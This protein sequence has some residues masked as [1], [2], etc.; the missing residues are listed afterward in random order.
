MIRNL[1]TDNFENN[2]SYFQYSKVTQWTKKKELKIFLA[3]KIAWLRNIGLEFKEIVLKPID[4]HSD[5]QKTEA[6]NVKVE[7]TQKT[8]IRTSPRKVLLAKDKILMS[9]KSYH[10]FKKDLNLNLPS[11][12]VIKKERKKLDSLF[13]MKKN[14]KGAFNNI[15]KMIEHKLKTTDLKNS[16]ELKF[17]F[18]ADG[19]IVSRKV[20][21]IN[22][23]FTI[24][25]EKG[26]AKTAKGNYTIGIF[27]MN[28]ENYDEIL[29]CFENVSD[30]I[31]SLEEVIYENKRYKITK[32]F[33][34]DLKILA[35]MCGINAA[36]SNFPCIWCTWNARI[37]SYSEKWS[38]TDPSNH[39][40]TQLNAIDKHNTQGYKHLPI[41][42]S[43]PFHHYIFDTLHKFLRITDVLMDCL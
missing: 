16:E 4:D 3:Q 40:R 26:K 11:L 28:D 27:R 34:G 22:L 7:T 20:K 43:I 36:N 8:E 6:I 12:Q 30:Q 37:K 17:K 42:K 2:K 9:D 14:T 23:T 38:I 18:S 21:L 25:N 33:G 41:L 29:A 31:D 24:I 13:E 10:S 32:Y 19:K 15:V 39:A 5:I 35:I 1:I